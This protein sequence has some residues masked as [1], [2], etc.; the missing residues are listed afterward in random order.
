MEINIDYLLLEEKD[1]YFLH[2]AFVGFIEDQLER[3]PHIIELKKD[4]NIQGIDE[5]IEGRLVEI[6]CEKTK[7]NESFFKD[8]P[9]EEIGHLLFFL[10]KITLLRISKNL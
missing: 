1:E 3:D 6:I 10:V 9:E 5:K 7:F 2:P 4:S 8:L